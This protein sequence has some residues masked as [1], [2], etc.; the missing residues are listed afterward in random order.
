MGAS[1][2]VCMMSSTSVVGVKDTTGPFDLFERR[3]PVV[4]DGSTP[5]GDV[6]G[7]RGPSCWHG[8]QKAIASELIDRAHMCCATPVKTW[9][10]RG[11]HNNAHQKLGRPRARAGPLGFEK[12][13]GR[14]ENFAWVQ[15]RLAS[16]PTHH[17]RPWPHATRP[18]YKTHFPFFFLGLPFFAFDFV[19][20]CVAGSN[21]TNAGDIVAE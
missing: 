7:C 17:T 5:G 11:H 8:P 15:Y 18:S 3:L 12:F 21:S 6:G 4:L 13:G 10:R 14:A 9:R 1:A 16:S 20:V 2:A 19:S